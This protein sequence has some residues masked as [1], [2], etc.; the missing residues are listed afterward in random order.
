MA[1]WLFFS[2]YGNDEV[3]FRR[4]SRSMNRYCGETQQPYR[5]LKSNRRSDK[6]QLQNVNQKKKKTF[7]ET[8][9][10]LIASWPCCRLNYS[11]PDMLLSPALQ[12]QAT[13]ASL[14]KRFFPLNLRILSMKRNSDVNLCLWLLISHLSYII[15]VI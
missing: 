12:K 1:F 5:Y 10:P 9:L 6:P 7:I 14:C 3:G 15:T 11:D 2:K 8:R 4:Y 13:S